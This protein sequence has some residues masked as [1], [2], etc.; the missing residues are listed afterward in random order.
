MQS[1]ASMFFTPT[2]CLLHTTNPTNAFTS[3]G[4]SSNGISPPNSQTKQQGKNS[5]AQEAKNHLRSDAPGDAD[6]WGF[7]CPNPSLNY[8]WPV[9]TFLF[10]RE[11]KA[12][13]KFQCPSGL[14]L[15]L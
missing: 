12:R 3:R 8:Q 6:I 14:N 4:N 15:P 13:Q 1:I 11:G 9:Y 5:D 2:S 10:P 7:L